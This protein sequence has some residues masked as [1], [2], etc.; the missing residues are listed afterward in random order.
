MRHSPVALVILLAALCAPAH[1]QTPE[2]ADLAA[3]VAEVEAKDPTRL[4]VARLPPEVIELNRDLFAQGLFLEAQLGA[5]GYWGDL[6]KVSKAGP[7]L[8]VSLGY[9]LA[10]WVSVLLQVGASF[11]DTSHPPP[12]ARTSYE[13]LEA[14][15]GLRLTVPLTTQAALW[16]DGL[17]GGVW[18][19][20]DVLRSLGFRDAV[21]PT[22]HYGGELGFDWHIRSRHHSLGMLG[23]GRI[24]PGLTRNRFSTGAYGSL[25]L[26]YVF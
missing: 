12:P 5:I 23:G 21:F 24:Y 13:L 15:V 7:R 6:G 18:T 14:L 26:R 25:Y 22:L 8:A 2:D 17:A 10:S 11:H 4:D 19:S 1:A 16:A 20:G 3:G 9:E